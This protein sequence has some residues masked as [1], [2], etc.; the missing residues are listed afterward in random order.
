MLHSCAT[1]YHYRIVQSNY[2]QVN[3]FQKQRNRNAWKNAG[4][5]INPLKK[6]ETFL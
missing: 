1:R 3:K 6:E 2:N 4:M 5:I